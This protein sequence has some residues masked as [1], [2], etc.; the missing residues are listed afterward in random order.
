MWHIVNALGVAACVL[1]AGAAASPTDEVD[2]GTEPEPVETVRGEPIDRGFVFVDGQ[3]LPPPYVVGR[4][5]D[6]LLINDR[7]VAK[8]WFA[9]RGPRPDRRTGMGPGR[10]HGD[11]PQSRGRRREE[12]RARTLEQLE[13]R[14]CTGG[15]LIWL[16]G[17]SAGFLE[18][19]SAIPVL[20]ILLCDASNEEKLQSLIDEEVRGVGSSQW[21]EILE[22]FQPTPELIERVG[23]VAAE[24]QRIADENETKHEK[25]ML[26]GFFRSKPMSYGV[27]IAAM[28]LAVVA[29]GNLLS[30]RP[31]NRSRW[32][33]VDTIGDGVPMVVRNVVLLILLGVFD[34]VLTLAAQQTGGFLELNP[35]GSQLVESPGLLIAFKI[36]TL[37]GAS[38]ILVSLR[39]YRGAQIASWWLCLVCTVL[40][41]R[42]LTYNSMFFA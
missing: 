17:G 4:R 16:D 32:R 42:W 38:L 21:A 25:L 19:E 12:G 14:L 8:D 13:D 20:D 36:V 1:L 11:F 34:L 33:D 30:Y 41:F 27:T 39:R 24:N 26:A 29:L 6:D 22:S 15:L 40:A 9:R 2:D 23:L 37:L 5:G 10:R 28:G 7:L 35:L 18:E 3:F 31:E